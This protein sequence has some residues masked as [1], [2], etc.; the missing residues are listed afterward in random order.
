MKMNR[1]EQNRSLFNRFLCMG[2]NVCRATSKGFWTVAC[3]YVSL[4][5]GTAFTSNRNGLNIVWCWH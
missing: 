4:D 1:G 2:Q 3:V 5:H